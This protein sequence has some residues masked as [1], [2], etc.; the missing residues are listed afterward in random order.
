MK[1][2]I[3]NQFG[4]SDVL[5]LADIPIPSIKDDEVLIQV[6]HTSVNPADWKIRAGLYEY[7]LPYKFP[8]I[9][10]WDAAGVISEVGCK[11]S[12]F[13]KGDRVFSYCRKPVI[14]QGSYA[15]YLAIDADAVAHIPDNISFA[16]AATIPMTGLTVWQCLFETIRLTAGQTILIH[17]GAGGIGSIA[18]QLAKLQQTTVYTTASLHNHDYVYSLGADIAIDYQN[19]DFVK[20]IA[21]REPAGI[22]LVLDTRGGEVQQ[23]SYQIIK[24]G[25]HLISLVTPPDD[26][27]A[28]AYQVHAEFV[29]GYPN[30]EQLKE[31]AKLLEKNQLKPTIYEEMSLE[32]AAIAHDMNR[33]GRLERGKLVLHITPSS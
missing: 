19:Q 23:N 8:I 2:M 21:A 30:G 20:E 10:G 3:I 11:V 13:K 18:I 17:G 31:L 16:E 5:Q 29:F 32:G 24:K 14:Q 12:R 33:N 22:D 28:A 26:D 25:G 15:E 7:L 9:L 4:D 27:E 1:A 6:S